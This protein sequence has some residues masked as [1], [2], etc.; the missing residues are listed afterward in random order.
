MKVVAILQARMNSTRLPGKS[1]LPLGGA[2][3]VQNIIERVRRATK[4]DAVVLAYPLADHESFKPILNRFVNTRGVFLGSYAF[5]GDENDLVAR[6]LA[7]A[8][9]YQADIIVRVPCDNPCVDPA[10]IDEL[11]ER[12]GSQCK[13]F[14]SN[15][16][17]LD[18]ATGQFVDG[19]GAEIFS[20]SRLKWLDRFTAGRAILREHPHRF[21]QLDGYGLLPNADVRLDVNTMEDYVFIKGIY[22]H[23]GHNQFTTAEVLMYLDTK[24][25]SA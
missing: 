4:L 15:T 2:P 25:G 20:I 22:D 10:Y 18:H 17:A 5:Q 19:V 7:A 12:Y 23:F 24:Q 11:V 1:L 8:S 6:Y 3:M 13:P 21:F 16:T 14:M 9:T